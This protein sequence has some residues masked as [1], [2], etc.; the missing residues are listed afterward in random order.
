MIER[1]LELGRDEEA[2][3]REPG[4]IDEGQLFVAADGRYQQ[5]GPLKRVGQGP[6]VVEVNLEELAVIQVLFKLRVILD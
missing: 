4:C 2:D 5:V 3:P 1:T 6:L